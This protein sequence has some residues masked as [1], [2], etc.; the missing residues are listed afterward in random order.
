[1]QDLWTS[2]DL[3][4][5]EIKTLKD[6]TALGL[7]SHKNELWRKFDKHFQQYKQ[8]LQA[9]SQKKKQNDEDPLIREKT[10]NEQLELMT[11]MA[12]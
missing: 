5:K 7:L 6:R 11:H 2:I 1:M 8:E 12:Q 3:I 4:E 9:D 10:L